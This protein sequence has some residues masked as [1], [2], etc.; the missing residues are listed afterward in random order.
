M[1]TEWQQ[2]HD[3]KIARA[4]TLLEKLSDG[5]LRRLTKK[6]AFRIGV[7]AIVPLARKHVPYHFLEMVLCLYVSVTIGIPF[8]SLVCMRL[9]L[10]LVLLLV[11][12]LAQPTDSILI[13]SE[14]P[15]T[16]PLQ[17]LRMPTSSAARHVASFQ[18]PFARAHCLSSAPTSSRPASGRVP[19]KTIRHLV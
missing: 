14:Q 6:K 19:L 8:H 3:Q 17:R 2:F 1:K 11:V 10:V 15:F 7:C 5:D 12:P 13:S 16:S 4:P 18:K 9:D